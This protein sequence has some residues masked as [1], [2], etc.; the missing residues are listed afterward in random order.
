MP[1]WEGV[2]TVSGFVDM[3]MRDFRAAKKGPLSRSLS[4]KRFLKFCYLFTGPTFRFVGFLLFLFSGMARPPDPCS[5]LSLFL[6]PSFPRW[7]SCCWLEVAATVPS[8]MALLLLQPAVRFHSHETH[9]VM[10]HT[11]SCSLN[12]NET[13]SY[14]SAQWLHRLI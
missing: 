4:S 12:F 14:S 1:G 13:F 6:S 9:T 7:Q 8:N 5:G 2:L 11:Q 3:N 10:R